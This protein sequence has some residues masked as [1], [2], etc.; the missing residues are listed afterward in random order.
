MSIADLR[1]SMEIDLAHLAPALRATIIVV[2]DVF[3][4]GGTFKAMQSLLTELPRVDEV[5]GIFLAKTV[6]PP[7]DFADLL[8]DE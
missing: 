4:Q 8:D 5:R 3:T 2:D 1:N 6:W 7:I